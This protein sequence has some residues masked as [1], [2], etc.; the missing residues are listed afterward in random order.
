MGKKITNGVI[1]LERSSEVS[2]VLILDS[3]ETKTTIKASTPIATKISKGVSTKKVSTSEKKVSTSNGGI[4]VEILENGE[5]EVVIN[6]RL[7]GKE[8]PSI[9]G[10]SFLD[11]P[12]TL[13][14]YINSINL[15]LIL[16]IVIIM[17]SVIVVI[18]KRR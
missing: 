14:Q 10:K 9:R 1:N 16:G 12:L 17:I 5:N 11:Y 2:S 13:G 15:I 3:D 4:S 8:T 7:D 6:K 18:L